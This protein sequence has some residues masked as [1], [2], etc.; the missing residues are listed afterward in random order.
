VTGNS[1]NSSVAALARAAYCAGFVEAAAD[2][3]SFLGVLDLPIRPANAERTQQAMRNCAGPS[4]DGED[5][6]RVVVRSSSST[7]RT[8]NKLR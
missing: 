7:P 6:L 8:V 3:G 2:A 4:V 5:L 1:Q